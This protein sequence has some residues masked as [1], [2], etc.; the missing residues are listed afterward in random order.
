MIEGE[1]RSDTGIIP[2]FSTEL[3]SR[4]V[5]EMEFAAALGKTC[6]DPRTDCQECWEFDGQPFFLQVSYWIEPSE[7]S[8]FRATEE[9]ALDLSAA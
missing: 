9:T 6:F 3:D 8:L 2:S 4:T 1:V 5:S 7:G